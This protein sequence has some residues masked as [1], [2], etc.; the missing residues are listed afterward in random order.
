MS[1]YIFFDPD[2]TES[3]IGTVNFNSNVLAIITSTGN[4]ANSDFLANTGVNYLNPTERGLEVGDSVTI[5][6][7][8]QISFNT[9]AMTPG[10]YVRVLT[11][12]SAQVPEPGTASLWVIG[13]GAMVF[14]R[15]PRS[16]WLMPGS[17]GTAIFR[18]SRFRADV[19][20]C[21]HWRFRRA[22]A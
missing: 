12:F 14:V 10:D 21:T 7:P 20:C 1:H 13:L 5:S 6:G 18:M 8:R 22:R 9:S 19:H 15:R 16:V 17:T 2:L 3:M 4:L 11:E